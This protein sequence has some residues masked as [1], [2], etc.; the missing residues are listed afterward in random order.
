[1]VSFVGASQTDYDN[2]NERVFSELSNDSS[3]GGN[4]DYY[5]FFSS[6]DS[7]SSESSDSSSN[8]LENIIID[9]IC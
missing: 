6:D 1:M 4:S 9:K 7:N 8:H 3:D 5:S 2:E